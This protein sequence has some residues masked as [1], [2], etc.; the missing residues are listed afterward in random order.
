M[1]HDPV[2]IIAALMRLEGATGV[3]THMREFHAYLQRVGH[4]HVVATPFHWLTL[5]W[6]AVLIGLRKALEWA[7]KPAAVA[8][9]RSGH[10]SLLGVRLAWLMWRHPGCVVYAQC[11]VSAGVAL[12]LCRRPGHRVVL[13]AHFNVSQADEWVGK[14]MLTR[15][16]WLDRRIRA[17]ESDVLQ[18]VHGQVFVSAFMQQQ[19]S[20]ACPGIASV[21]SVV[22]PNFV[23]PL[24]DRQPLPGMAGRDLI[25]IGTLEPRKN[26]GYLLRVLAEA[27]RRGR[28]LSLTLVGDGPL[29]ASLARQVEEAGLSE[30]VCFVGFTPH[31]RAHIPGHRL[32]VHA[33][34]MESQG[35]VLLE[36]MSA[37]VPVVAA[38]VGGIPE[39]FDDG[40]EGRF[41]PL[42]DVARACDT[43]LGLL[44]DEAN[45]VL[46]GQA[47]LKRFSDRFEASVA[48][49]SL[50][51]YLLERGRA[52][53][54]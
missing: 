20:Q 37:G 7:W 43:L 25:S 21:S 18:R 31:G 36:A 54:P 12:R 19:L 28:S 24:L 39:V 52:A 32:Y 23:Q 26:Q 42:D 51:A 44:D 10:A 41:W 2:I 35:I 47:A 38:H 15:G 46:M 30:Q 27:K 8:L 29:R 13:V 49:R 22:I 5:P 6:L 40:V 16:S 3:Q 34:L 1:S 48:A 45:R 4:P 50:L 11:P 53:Q 14:G 17:L 9:Y 33:A